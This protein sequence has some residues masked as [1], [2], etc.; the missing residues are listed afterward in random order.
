[1]IILLNIVQQNTE[2]TKQYMRC[3]RKTNV[4]EIIYSCKLPIKNWSNFAC[5]SYRSN[6]KINFV[7]GCKSIQHDC[8]CISP[9]EIVRNVR[10]DVS[11]TGII[12]IG[13]MLPMT[14]HKNDY[15]TGKYYASAMFIAQ[16][17]INADNTLL[18]NHSLKL[19]WTNT[20]CNPAKSISQLIDFT[21]KVVDAFVF[22]GCSREECLTAARIATAVNKP[23][24][25]HVSNNIQIECV[26]LRNIHRNPVNYCNI[27]SLE[28]I[29]LYK[30][31][32]M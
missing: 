31:I 29:G 24:L 1:M 16:D 10:C 6:Q 3:W 8:D 2:M 22:G 15:I 11:S 9:Q 30:Y 27:I 19:E 18:A 4:T 25:S 7:C 17:D 21:I 28:L 20:E 12:N 5:Y 32:L 14:Y 23:M 26:L 13:V